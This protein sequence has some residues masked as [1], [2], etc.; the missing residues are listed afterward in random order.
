MGSRLEGLPSLAFA[1]GIES[2]LQGLSFALS[3]LQ[4]AVRGVT[5]P[6]WREIESALVSAIAGQFRTVPQ[7]QHRT[8][9]RRLPLQ[10][11]KSPR[12]LD[13]QDLRLRYR[14]VPRAVPGAVCLDT[15]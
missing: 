14:R 1:A 2:S 4:C 9:P 6:S 5:C 13:R 7:I 3:A 11:L 15:R 10:P 12:L 8:L